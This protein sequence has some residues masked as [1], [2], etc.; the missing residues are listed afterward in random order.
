MAVQVDI[1]VQTSGPSP[2]PISG[3]LVSLF[4]PAN[5]YALAGAATSDVNGLAAFMLP[6]D[7]PGLQ[8]E[9]RAYKLG[10]SFGGI[11][12]VVVVEPIP[13]GEPATYNTFD[14]FGTPFTAATATDPRLCRC[15]G[16]FLDFSNQAMAGGIVRI[17]TK[18]SGFQ[19]PRVVDGNMIAGE[20]KVLTVDANGYVVVD[21]HRG[22]EY[23]ITFSGELDVVWT[24]KVP[25]LPSANL[26]DL[27]CPYPVS[28]TWDPTVAPNDAVSFPVGFGLSIP[29]TVLF[30]TGEERTTGL[31]TWLLVSSSDEAIA[32]AQL[33]DSSVVV[34][35]LSPGVAL[36]L[37]ECKPGSY[38]SRIPPPSILPVPLT[39]T[40]TPTP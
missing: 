24:I 2:V 6:G 36:V 34:T 16:R 32:T 10:V 18:E 14:L 39:V 13:V 30:N 17:F 15:T 21:L 25:D 1:Y 5:A 38:P 35:G 37:L 26:V 40:V 22:G 4:D 27:I 31:P 3:V 12:R 33:T 29:L 11:T 23:N 8:Y 7:D 19:V 28:I 20:S 9:A